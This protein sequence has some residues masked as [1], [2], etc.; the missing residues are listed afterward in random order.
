MAATAKPK[1]KKP[2]KPG[3]RRAKERA[4][5]GMPAIPPQYRPENEEKPKPKCGGPLGNQFWRMRSSHGRNPIFETPEKL[6]E[7]CKEY[8]DWN[9]S[10]PLYE[11][12]VSFYQGEAFHDQKAKLRAMT[13]DALIIFLDISTSSW[14]QYTKRDGFKE[15]CTRVQ[16]IIRNQKFQ[17]ASADLLN[18]LIIARDLGLRD[19]QDFTHAGP[20]GGPIQTMQIEFVKADHD[21]E[22]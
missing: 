19:K 13:F 5:I 14:D 4:A 1:K 20:D 8:F 22:G 7:A 18:P 6:W 10:H 21:N 12:S 3:M 2:T 9:E 16:R 11:D 15:V 17:G